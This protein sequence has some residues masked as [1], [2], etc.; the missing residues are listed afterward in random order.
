M[1][2]KQYEEAVP[3]LRKCARLEPHPAP[4]YYRLQTAERNLHQTEA[5]DRDLKIFQTLSRDPNS[6]ALRLSE[7]FR[8]SGPESWP[9]SPTTGAV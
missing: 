3:L 4:V 2:E 6:S 9:Y 7:H 8:L 1:H 5:A